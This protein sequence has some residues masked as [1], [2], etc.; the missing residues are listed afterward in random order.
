MKPC[1]G[2]LLTKGRMAILII[3]A[4]L[5]IDQ[6]TKVWVKTNMVLHETIA[7][8]DWFK[9]CFIENNGMAYGME[10]GSKLALTLFRI[11]AI[12]LIGYY[13][14]LQVRKGAKTGYIICLSLIIA[15]AIGN[16]ID[17]MFYGLIS[18][19]SSDFYT[20]FF[21]PWGTGYSNFLMGKVVDMLYFPLIVSVWPD[22][23]PVV[24]GENFVFFSPVFNIADS[25]ISVGVILLL[26]LYRKEISHISLSSNARKHD[27]NEQ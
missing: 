6:T 2:N 21:V 19:A 26:L 12:S 10:I 18:S 1:K 14:H 8:T 23:V 5:L 22:W 17:S 15:G 27:D 13:L 25:S 7:V 4:I 3:I 20:S 9:I 16:V 11:V 24:G